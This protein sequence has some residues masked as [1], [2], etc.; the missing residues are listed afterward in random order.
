MVVDKKEASK[1]R[2]P[3][4]KFEVITSQ[5]LCHRYMINHYRIY[6]SNDHGYVQSCPY[7]TD[8]CISNM[9][10]MTDAYR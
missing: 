9:R 3:G 10:N 1:P 7:M 8:Y 5:V 2:V 4:G 6:V